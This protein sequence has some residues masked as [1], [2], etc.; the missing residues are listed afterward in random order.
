MNYE[1]KYLKYKNKYTKFNQQQIG[2]TPL[3]DANTI[4]QLLFQK[5]QIDKTISDN[6][7]SIHE[8][9]I[10]WKPYFHKSELECLPT[11]RLEKC[12]NTLNSED[13]SIIHHAFQYGTNKALNLI[14]KTKRLNI[15]LLNGVGRT[16]IIGAALELNNYLQ[17]NSRISDFLLLGGDITLSNQINVNGLNFKE[18]VF[19]I[20][21]FRINQQQSNE[22][23]PPGTNPYKPLNINIPEDNQ[24]IGIYSF[25]LGNVSRY[26][27]LPLKKPIFL[28]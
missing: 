22:L 4:C 27:P 9:N 7:I 23:F 18:D 28:K 2:G 17:I 19:L 16:A 21:N 24:N 8:F 3:E 11:Q 5:V 1:Q 6:D 20:L 10:P 26:M 14:L 15:N 25:T 13:N 12:I